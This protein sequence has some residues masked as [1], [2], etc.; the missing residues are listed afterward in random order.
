M[1]RR[2]SRRTRESGGGNTHDR[3][4]ITYADLITL[5]MIF[6]V[7]MYAVSKV[8]QTKFQTLSLS[9]SAALQ[10]NDRIQ[11]E[12]SPS[13]LPNSNPGSKSEQQ[14][15]EEEQQ[16]L[17]ELQKRLEDYVQGQGLAGQVHVI[18]TSRGV[19]LTLNDAALFASGQADVKP[20][21]ER[22]LNGLA[23]FLRLVSN[24]VAVEGHTDDVPIGISNAQFRSNWELSSQ[25]AINV[26]HAFEAAGVPHGRLSAEGYADTK[27]LAPNDSEANRAANRRVNLIVLRAHPVEPISPLE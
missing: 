11:L 26:L 19:Q 15:R 6:F 1:A 22:L 12:G 18:E 7:V 25:R 4:L 17:D 9:L 21:A 13:L 16:R 2:R 24:P 20:E 14:K 23:P 5:L 3:W 8:D 27:P 10:T